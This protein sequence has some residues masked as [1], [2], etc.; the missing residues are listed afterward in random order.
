[1]KRSLIKNTMSITRK[2]IK[3]LVLGG[4]IYSS[5]LSLVQAG[6]VVG[7][8]KR[9]IE[10]RLPATSLTYELAGRF[11]QVKKGVFI[12]GIDFN[13]FWGHGSRQ[14]AIEMTME[15]C[16]KA[17][18]QFC[19]IVPG[20]EKLTPFVSW[21]QQYPNVQ[22]RFDNGLQSKGGFIEDNSPYVIMDGDV[23]KVGS[24]EITYISVNDWSDHLEDFMAM[25]KKLDP[26][27]AKQNRFLK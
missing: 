20:P 16:A 15:K 25:W 18:I 23:L 26:K 6:D 11:A 21:A 24:S 2:T 10:V 12:K 19:F 1:M 22:V 9:P 3:A 27:N 8:S 14:S 5:G 4:A 17:G 13:N 7:F